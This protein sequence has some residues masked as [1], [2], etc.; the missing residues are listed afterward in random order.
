[1]YGI[2]RLQFEFGLNVIR[3]HLRIGDG[4]GNYVVKIWWTDERNRQ[5]KSNV[6]QLFRFST[7]FQI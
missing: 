3:A 2:C 7:E 1:M 6:G 4:A 5:D